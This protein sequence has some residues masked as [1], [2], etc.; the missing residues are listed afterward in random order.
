MA[1]IHRDIHLQSDP[2]TV[3]DAVRDVGAAHVR[4]TPGVLTATEFDGHARLVTFADGWQVREVIVDVDDDRQRLAYA[5]V[6]GVFTHHHASMEVAADG[7]G[8]S[9]LVWTTDLLPHDAA[10]TVE[11][12]VDQGVAAMRDVFDG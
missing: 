2:A 12:F 10:P 1:T 6:D 8:R 9:R 4:L 5:V 11:A 7:E 3:W